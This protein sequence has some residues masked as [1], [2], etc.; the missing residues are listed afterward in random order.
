MLTIT[1]NRLFPTHIP[2]RDRV[3]LLSCMDLRLLDN[4]VSFM[5]YENLTN[6]YDQFILAGASLGIE[7][8]PSWEKAFF[9]HL[10]LAI[11]LHNITD[12]YILEHRNCGAYHQ[13]LGK[14]GIFGDKDKDQDREHKL[15]RKYADQL[16]DHIGQ[17]VKKKKLP[18]LGVYSFLMD[19]RGNVEKLSDRKKYE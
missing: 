12:V 7:I 17:R 16:A 11:K 2:A 4:I 6:R 5:N 10:E 3:M 19:L 18:K 9:S 14:K 8:D 15:H 1:H 13:H